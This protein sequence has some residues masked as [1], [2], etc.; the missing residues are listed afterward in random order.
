[1]RKIK[2]QKNYEECE[3]REDVLIECALCSEKTP[4]VF[5]NN[6]IPLVDARVCE[7]CNWEK[8]YPARLKGVNK[9]TTLEYPTMELELG[10]DTKEYKL[11]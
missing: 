4:E 7:K 8:V 1:M 5:S 10:P 11:N 3:F 6:G 2:T 9:G